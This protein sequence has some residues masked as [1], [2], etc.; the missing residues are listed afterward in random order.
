MG[1]NFY[2]L[3]Q[4]LEIDRTYFDCGNQNINKFLKD[5]AEACERERLSRVFLMI[6]DK[7]E[8]VGY[9]SLGNSK[10]PLSEIPN[11]YKRKMP[12]Y[13]FPAILIGQFG[14]DKNWQGQK[15]SYMLFGDVCR[16]IVLNYQQ[17]SSAFNAVMVE[18][19]KEDEQAKKFWEKMGFI[20]FKNSSYSLFIPVKTILNTFEQ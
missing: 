13:P 3:S 17:S 18:T 20:P 2:S 1:W 9:Y 10:I 14:V 11:K 4:A 12:N 6:S 7:N 19:D 16:R 8:I 15:L 5:S